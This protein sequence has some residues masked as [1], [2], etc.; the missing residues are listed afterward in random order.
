MGITKWSVYQIII[1][2]LLVVL[3]FLAERFNQVIAIQPS[4]NE[5][6]TFIPMLVTISFVVLVIFLSSLFFYFQTKKSNTFLCH[7]LWNKMPLI[8]PVVFSVI[9]IIML[10]LYMMTSL[11]AQRWYMYV[12][13]YFSLFT[14]NLFVLSIVN[15]MDNQHSLSVKVKY[16]GAATAFLILVILY[17]I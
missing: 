12:I 14:A 13:I 16:A 7:P 1:L 2:L 5:Q 4:N 10:A 9:L 15:K 3:A 8:I 17:V 6:V 11:Q